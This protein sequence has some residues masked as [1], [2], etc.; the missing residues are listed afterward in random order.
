MNNGM[1]VLPTTR[2]RVKPA[3]TDAPPAPTVELTMRADEVRIDD[4]VLRR[5]YRPTDGWATVHHVVEEPGAVS[6]VLSVGGCLYYAADHPVAVRRRMKG[7][8]S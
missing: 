5:P 4:T 7:V 3:P 6:L 8:A 1:P 2:R